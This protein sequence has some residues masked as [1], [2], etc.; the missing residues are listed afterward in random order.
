MLISAK[1]KN[2]KIVAT[3]AQ[4]IVPFRDFATEMRKE[5]K[6]GWTKEK[7]MRWVGRIPESSIEKYEE[8]HPGFKKLAFGVV[9]DWKL[10]DKVMREFMKWQEN[11]QFMWGKV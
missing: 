2:D 1:Y 10:R 11:Q 3:H 5:H 4:N 8:T 6:P 7:T 9:G